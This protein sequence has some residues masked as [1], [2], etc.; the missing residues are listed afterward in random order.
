MCVCI[1]QFQVC[2]GF[3]CA[4]RPLENK[5]TDLVLANSYWERCPCLGNK[6]IYVLENDILN[7][8]ADMSNSDRDTPICS[9]GGS[10]GSRCHNLKIMCLHIDE[11]WSVFR[12]C[13]PLL[14]IPNGGLCARYKVCSDF[15]RCTFSH[16]LHDLPNARPL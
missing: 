10:T 5:R 13:T 1:S 2:C 12:C 3:I 6:V 9:R 11:W 8:C 15:N 7:K 16:W 4:V 14:L